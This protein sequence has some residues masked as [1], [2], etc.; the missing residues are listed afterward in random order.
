MTATDTLLT[1]TDGR[2]TLGFVLKRGRD[3]AEG[4]D[5]NNKTVGVFKNEDEAARAVW[6]AAHGQ[7]SR[8]A[9]HV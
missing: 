9:P 7:A 1:V 6:R 2:T 8:E 4:F 3:G 5:V